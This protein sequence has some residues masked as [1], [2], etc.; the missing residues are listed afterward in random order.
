MLG[1]YVKYITIL[2]VAGARRGVPVEQSRSID[3]SIY[4]YTPNIYI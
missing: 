1:K 4:R 2:G 3:S